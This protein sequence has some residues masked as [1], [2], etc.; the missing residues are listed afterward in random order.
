MFLCV[1]GLG[2]KP[3]VVPMLALAALAFASMLLIFIL[4]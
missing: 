1:V 4:M 3:R 2:H